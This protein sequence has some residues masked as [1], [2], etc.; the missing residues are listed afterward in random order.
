MKTMF[1][2]GGGPLLSGVLLALCFPTWQLFFLAWVALAPLFYVCRNTTP[3]PTALRFFVAGWAFHSVVLQWLLTNMYW[4]GGWAFWGQQAVCLVMAAYWAITGAAWAWL[5]GRLRWMPQSLLLAVLWATMEYAQNHLLSGFGWSNLAYSQGRDLL[6]LQLAA[7]G[8]TPLI[9]GLLV[10][11]NVLFSELFHAHRLRLARAALALALL[12]GSH[13][14]GMALLQPAV[15]ASPPFKAGVFQSNF[16]LEMKWDPEY[17]LEMVRNAAEKSRLLAEH[18]PVNLFVWPETLVMDDLTAPGI[19]APLEELT[20][21]TGAALYTGS[22]RIDAETGRA[23]N[24]S[25]LISPSGAV[26]GHYDKIHLAPFGEYVPFGSY[27]PFIQKIVPI[28]SDVEPGRETRVFSLEERTFGPL[29]CFEVLFAE[30]SEALRRQGADFLVVITNLGWF[31]ASNALEQELEQAR[32]RAIETRL[33]LVHCANTGLSGVF[34]PWGR[35]TATN[36]VVMPSGTFHWLRE[37]PSA[38]DLKQYRC[39]GTLP[40]AEPAARPVP[41]APQRVPQASVAVSVVFVALAIAPRRR[42][43]PG[44]AA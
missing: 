21:S 39:L 36:A 33:A 2:Q 15:Y 32:L 23:R 29:I 27:F 24:S 1:R 40:V 4:A 31:G 43:A 34:D 37:D 30:M 42:P 25:F 35:F 28:I 17:S 16:P 3:R 26:E 14:V 10:A 6:L 9:A 12:I 20:R 44:P 41:W 5:R 38:R 8:G 7:I 11:S 13:G 19:L 22:Q 18:A